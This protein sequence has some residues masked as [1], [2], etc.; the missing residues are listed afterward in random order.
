MCC[1]TSVMCTLTTTTAAAQYRRTDRDTTR[2]RE[3]TMSRTALTAPS[4]VVELRSEHDA[5]IALTF[6]RADSARAWYES[7]RIAMVAPQGRQEP[8]T[9]AALQR[10]FVLSVDARGR[11]RTLSAPEFPAAFEGITDLSQ[12]F[13]DLLVRLPN[14]PLARGLVWADTVIDEKRGSNEAQSRGERVIRSRVVRDTVIGEESAWV[15]ESVQRV[16]IVGTQPVKGQPLVVRTKLTGA[17][18]GTV[19]FSAQQG[20][21][22]ARQRVGKLAG[23]LTYEGGP[24]PVV[25]PMEQR[26]EN[27]VTRIP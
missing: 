13:V 5:T 22:L 1:V 12:Q 2:L 21:M 8:V 11:V 24:Q 17:D 23:T 25:L 20:R 26:Y 15:I 10:P 9:S 14:A 18:S 16:T 19:V 7:L 3:V 27:T 6:G 4:G